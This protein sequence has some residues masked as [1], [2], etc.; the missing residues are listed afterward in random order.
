MCRP[1]PLEFLLIAIWGRGDDCEAGTVPTAVVWEF[2]ALDSVAFKLGGD[3]KNGSRT[4]KLRR[5]AGVSGTG[6]PGTRFSRDGVGEREPAAE[7]LS[8]PGP[9]ER[10]AF[11]RSGVGERRTSERIL[12]QPD[13]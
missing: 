1:S 5:S 8:G 12:W 11:A 2:P 10:A 4:C 6:A 7:I 9:P 3:C 13:L